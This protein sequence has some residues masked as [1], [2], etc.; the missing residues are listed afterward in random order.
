M[1]RLLEDR[2]EEWINK[3]AVKLNHMA[4]QKDTKY[5]GKPQK[6]QGKKNEMRSGTC[7]LS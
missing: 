6:Y 4:K 2:R 5:C 7:N 3:E 1:G